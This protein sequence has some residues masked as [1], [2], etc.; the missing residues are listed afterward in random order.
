MVEDLSPKLGPLASEIN[1]LSRDDFLKSIKAHTLSFV[2]FYDYE[3]ISRPDITFFK[4]IQL[5]VNQLKKDGLDATFGFYNDKVDH[6]MA[7]TYFLHYHTLPKLKVFYRGEALTYSGGNRSTHI[8]A[9]VKR[10]TREV[11]P[12]TLEIKELNQFKSLM[13]DV[14]LLAVY[15][16]DLDSADYKV[17][18]EAMGQLKSP[19][20]THTRQDECLQYLLNMTNPVTGDSEP[21]SIL[22]RHQVNEVFLMNTDLV[23]KNQG[24][25]RLYSGFKVGDIAKEFKKLSEY[26][27]MVLN[28]KMTNIK[29]KKQT[30][31]M[32][33]RDFGKR[34]AWFE[35][36]CSQNQIS[37]SCY[38]LDKDMED[39][40]AFWQYAIGFRLTG[41]V[42]VMLL[43]HVMHQDVSSSPKKYLL[44][45]EN[46]LSEGDFA[47][48]YKGYLENELEQ[49]VKSEPVP[50]TVVMDGDVTV[51]VAD[52][53]QEIVKENTDNEIL[54]YI[55][56][57]NCEVCEEVSP[58]F[59][60][61]ATTL[62]T[63]YPSVPIKLMKINNHLNDV[64]G[65]NV[66]GYPSFYL[67]LL[68]DK[69]APLA[70]GWPRF[71]HDE[72]L[73]HMRNFPAWKDADL[74][75]L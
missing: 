52:N 8:K 11:K 18:L 10:I 12:S 22:D 4:E 34:E 59:N 47:K 65:V 70:M 58:I 25:S 1:I 23:G 55:H 49:F 17:Y 43:A 31:F 28:K 15:Y 64:P 26:K 39:T 54:L 67:Y 48:F 50:E 27:V 30:F 21:P 44:K 33:D 38:F 66:E 7:D 61:L 16:G 68:E 74:Q 42:Q 60:Q 36:F 9:W 35:K 69:T 63:K 13:Q 53:F 6:W 32:I 71:E 62:K 72:V 14:D 20:F 2:A 57:P 37:I 3:D 73:N 46:I 56:S 75:D 51:V 40:K 29:R 19:L 5:T 41:K 45:S 24:I